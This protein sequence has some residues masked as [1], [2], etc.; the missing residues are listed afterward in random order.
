[1]KKKVYGQLRPI[2][3]SKPNE[4]AQIDVTYMPNHDGFLYIVVLVDCFSKFM[5]AKATRHRDAPT[6]KAFLQSVFQT[7][8]KWE[9]LQSDNGGEFVNRILEDFL[10]EEGVK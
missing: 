8:Q 7:G 4:R 2:L 10:Q 9:I 3:A 5:W 1:M 6:I